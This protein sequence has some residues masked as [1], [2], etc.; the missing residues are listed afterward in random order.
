MKNIMQKILIS[1]YYGFHNTG[2]EL[3]LQEIIR[4]L[5]DSNPNV[6]ITVL[7]A[8]PEHTRNKYAVEAK[9]RWSF[10]QVIKGIIKTDV[11]ISG[12]GS[13]LQ[14]KTSKN[15]IIYYLGI[16]FLGKVFAKKVVV[17][18]QGVGPVTNSRNVYFLKKSLSLTDYIS[19]RD[20][21]SLELLKKIG[22]KKDIIL[23]GDPVFLIETK[24]E[25]TRNELWKQ[26]ALEEEKKLITVSLR[27]WDNIDKIIEETKI[28]LERFDRDVYQVRYL[29]FHEGEDDKIIAGKVPEEEVLKGPTK[30]EDLASLIGFSE[31]TIG[32]RLHSLILAAAQSVK[33]ISISYDP[34]VDA[35]DKEIYN[36]NINITANNISRDILGEKFKI[37]DQ[38]KYNNEEIKKRAL[39]PFEYLKDR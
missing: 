5:K 38:Y 18:S 19:V 17:F 37:V 15:G 16:I 22:I 2:D 29:S 4:G 25:D 32:M 21:D 39:K 36:S 13:L 14:D 33:F 26:F 24:D 23:S 31:L 28:F 8:D 30:P 20:E 6:K 27:P 9:D 7:S 1:G 10:F 34:K 3:V 11:L 35:L 12:G